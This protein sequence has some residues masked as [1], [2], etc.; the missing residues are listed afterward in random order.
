MRDALRNALG[1]QEDQLDE[2]L[3]SMAHDEPTMRVRL[4]WQSAVTHDPSK[5]GEAEPGTRAEWTIEVA[6]VVASGGFGGEA[7][8]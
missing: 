4:H 7:G 8:G 5:A 3:E 2:L 6:E 1:L